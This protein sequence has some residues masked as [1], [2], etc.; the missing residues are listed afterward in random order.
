M[1]E[2]LML[3]DQQAYEAVTLLRKL[4]ADSPE[5][6]QKWDA[7]VDASIRAPQAILATAVAVL[8]LC[9]NIINFVNPMLLSDLAVA[10]DYAMATA[11]CGVYNVKINLPE[12]A[13]PEARTAIE[14]QVNELLTRASRIIQR[15]SPRIWERVA[16]G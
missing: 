10:T 8:E 5:R 15:A 7:A 1:F 16:Q 13:N 6:Q 2:Q 4:P 3:E 11:R 14:L 9:D 12:V